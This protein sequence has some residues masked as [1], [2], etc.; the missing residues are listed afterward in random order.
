M[1]WVWELRFKNWMSWGP[2][3]VGTMGWGLKSLHTHL[4]FSSR[5]M[6]KGCCLE[7]LNS[8]LNFNLRIKNTDSFTRLQCQILTFFTVVL[9]M[10]HNSAPIQKW[11]PSAFWNAE[12]ISNGGF[13]ISGQEVIRDSKLIRILLPSGFTLKLCLHENAC[14]LQLTCIF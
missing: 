14:C 4:Y 8:R 7:L 10:L 2:H 6:V 3:V 9:K 13:R 1:Q 11:Q 5:L 12:F